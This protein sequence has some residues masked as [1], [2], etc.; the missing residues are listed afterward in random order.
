M[1]NQSRK[2]KSV[3]AFRTMVLMAFQI[4]AAVL[5]HIRGRKRPPGDMNQT[6]Q[7]SS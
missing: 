3:P 4:S 5:R 7:K 1:Q 6:A 2:I